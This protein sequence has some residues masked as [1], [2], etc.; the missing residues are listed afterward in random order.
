MCHIILYKV[1]VFRKKWVS[2]HLLRI[3]ES[4]EDSHD[5]RRVPCLSRLH[6]PSS[7]WLRISFWPSASRWLSALSFTLGTPDRQNLYAAKGAVSKWL[8]QA[9]RG[10]AF[11]CVN[12]GRTKTKCRKNGTQN[13]VFIG[14][15]SRLS[16][17]RRRATIRTAQKARPE[18]EGLHGNLCD[19][20]P[21]GPRRHPNGGN[22]LCPNEEGWRD[23]TPRRA[24]SEKCLILMIFLIVWWPRKT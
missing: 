9:M 16:Y 21:D 20:R 7:L 17:N 5:R 8:N 11:F 1:S 22:R 12:F 6:P 4:R 3:H 14:I 18:C 23:E 15:S 2:I 10:S 19:C 24:G 13:T